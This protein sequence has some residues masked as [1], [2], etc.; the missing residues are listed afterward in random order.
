MHVLV[1][2]S[3]RYVTEDSPTGGIFQR[4]QVLG[5]SRAGLRVGVLAAAPRPWGALRKKICGWRT[6]VETGLDQDVPVFRYHGWNPVRGHVRFVTP[7]I[8]LHSGR[9]LFDRY[10]RQFGK[11][12]LL[13]AHNSL[14]AGFLAGHLGKEHGIPVIVTEHSTQL[15][16]GETRPW[17]D[18]CVLHALRSSAVRI[19]VSSSLGRKMETR[20]GVAASPWELIPN[21]LDRV[22]EGGPEP[23]ARH[24]GGFRILN[25]A[26]MVARKN[27][28]G[29][30]RAFALATRATQGL[31]LRLG[32]DGPLRAQLEKQARELGI[33]DRVVF[34]GEIGRDKVL[35]EMS[36]CDL[37]VLPSDYETFGVVLI[38]ALACGKP[39]VS[40]RCGG[41]EDIVHGGNGMLVPVRDE[42]ALAKAIGDIHDNIELYDPEDLRRECL[43]RYGT[44]AVTAK[45]EEAY[46]RVLRQGP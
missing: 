46:R 17:E 3:E 27:H 5:L 30:L 25:V 43:Q 18:A 4:D 7:R 42:Q 24:T 10:L 40:T 34:L 33:G 20:Y 11:P 31:E 26:G 9:L 44:Q 39:V 19:F 21:I 36:G 32:G 8:W 13:H 1:M 38:E 14:F 23:A 22:F 41:P 12:D 29:L 35:E 37:F 2:P 16:R 6:G 45:L 15:A 28:E